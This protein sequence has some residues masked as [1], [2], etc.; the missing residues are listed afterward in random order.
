MYIHSFI[1]PSIHPFIHSSINLFIH[2]FIHPFT[3]S[4]FIHSFLFF[5]KYHF[6]FSDGMGME[7]TSV[8]LIFEPLQYMPWE[9]YLQSDL[10]KRRFL[11]N[12]IAR[13]SDVLS[14]PRPL[15]RIIGLSS[16]NS[17]CNQNKSNR[18]K[19]I[20]T[21]LF[22]PNVTTLIDETCYKLSDH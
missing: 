17:D 4:F 1:H 22:N 14:Y 6:L 21:S 5:S 16:G 15:L 3:H 12:V 11:D 10:V 7:K 9:M 8:H 18:I 13:V 19:N 2:S 20:A